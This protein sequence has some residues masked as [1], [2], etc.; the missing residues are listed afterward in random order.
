MSGWFFFL[1]SI[2]F[3]RCVCAL[4]YVHYPGGKHNAQSVCARGHSAL[5]HVHQCFVFAGWKPHFTRQTRDPIP[6]G[7]E[8]IS[9]LPNMILFLLISKPSLC[10]QSGDSGVGSRRGPGRRLW[11]RRHGPCARQGGVPGVAAILT[12]EW[13]CT[14][15]GLAGAVKKRF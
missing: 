11:F 1:L 10:N 12:M 6:M 13:K 14:Y 5:P 15:S 9:I 8:H 7:P 3:S 2:W 4:R